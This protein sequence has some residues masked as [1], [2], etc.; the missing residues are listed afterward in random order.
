MIDALISCKNN[1]F[2]FIVIRIEMIL[3]RDVYQKIMFVTMILKS[4]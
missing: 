1:R 4:M 3:D 2:F